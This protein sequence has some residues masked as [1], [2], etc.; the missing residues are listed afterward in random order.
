MPSSH[1][2][3]R[4]VHKHHGHHRHHHGHRIG[5]TGAAGA[6]GVRSHPHRHHHCHRIGPNGPTGATGVTGP[7]GGGEAAFDIIFIPFATGPGVNVVTGATGQPTIV[8]LMGFGAAFPA[9]V[10]DS[11][12]INTVEQ[13]CSFGLRAPG[14]SHLDTIQGTF[15]N[16]SP[17][18]SAVTDGQTG[19]IS[20]Q[21]YETSG[22]GSTYFPLA[23]AVVSVPVFIPPG[24]TPAGSIVA[25][26]QNTVL[27]D[28]QILGGHRYTLGAV[29]SGVPNT[30]MF[31]VVDSGVVVTLR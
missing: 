25:D 1:E 2:R 3:H 4:K 18:V 31:G 21:V 10:G 17:V 7:T 12:S 22:A 26:L 6:P 23:G 20:L 16:V 27:L 30:R 11:G 5:S 19:S 15:I 14:N 29:L 24:T 13:M 9:Q 28:V 8:G